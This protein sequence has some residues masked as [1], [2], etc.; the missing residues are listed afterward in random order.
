LAAPILD[1]QPLL[2]FDLDAEPAYLD[3]VATVSRLAK[4]ALDL[5]PQ[6]LSQ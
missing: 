2:A 4:L 5:K 6:L 3:V 1:G